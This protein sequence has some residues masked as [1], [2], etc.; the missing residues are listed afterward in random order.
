M[1]ST[2]KPGSFSNPELRRGSYTRPGYLH[3]GAAHIIPKML[4][5][6]NDWPEVR[7]LLQR[8][9]VDCAG[10]SARRMPLGQGRCGRLEHTCEAQVAMPAIVA[11]QRRER[12]VVSDLACRREDLRGGPAL[13]LAELLGRRAIAAQPP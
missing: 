6:S 10:S 11:Y 7:R 4:R 12:R 8:R 5:T 2:I 13:A 3:W 9:R 1:P